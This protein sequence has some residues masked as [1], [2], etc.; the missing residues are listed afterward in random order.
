MILPLQ[1]RTAITEKRIAALSHVHDGIRKHVADLK[2]RLVQLH[3][4]SGIPQHAFAAR[5]EAEC[6]A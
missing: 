6:F 5:E 4:E 3:E 1:E 2:R